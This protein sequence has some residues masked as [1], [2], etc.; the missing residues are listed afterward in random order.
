MLTNP[1]IF[2]LSFLLLLLFICSKCLILI[3]FRLFFIHLCTVSIFHIRV[4]RRKYF[5]RRRPGIYCIYILSFLHLILLSLHLFIYV[6]IFC[7]VIFI[8]LFFFFVFFS[9]AVYIHCFIYFHC[10][11]CS[12]SERLFI[13][14]R[15]LSVYIPIS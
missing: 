15:L 10:F 3:H 5:M 4:I 11:I 12:L 13:K 1:R 14:R 8:S 6:Y 2:S 9:T 7:I